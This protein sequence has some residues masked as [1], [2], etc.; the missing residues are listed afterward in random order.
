MSINYYGE[1]CNNAVIIREALISDVPQISKVHIDSWKITYKNLLPETILEKLSY[2]NSEHLW[3]KILIHPLSNAKIYVALYNDKI[4]GFC[5][6]EALQEKGKIHA[7]YILPEY[8]RLRIGSHLLF[9]SIDFLETMGCKN[10]EL[11]VLPGNPS[12]GFYQKLCGEN[13]EIRPIDISDYKAEEQIIRWK[14]IKAL[15][16]ALNELICTS[17]RPEE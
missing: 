12:M 1:N 11:G 14:S 15:K 13:A 16:S 5:S 3:A 7:L 4:V 8:Q 17:A 6:V 9:K 10:I 2:D